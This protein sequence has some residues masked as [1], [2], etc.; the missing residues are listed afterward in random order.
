MEIINV[1]RKANG[2]QYLFQ[3]NDL[4]INNLSSQFSESGIF[5]RIE[6]ENVSSFEFRYSGGA[7]ELS[8]PIECRP[9]VGY[10]LTITRINPT[11]PASVKFIAFD[12]SISN[13]QLTIDPLPVNG[14]RLYWVMPDY[15]TLDVF[16]L[17][18]YNPLDPSTYDPNHV[19]F[20]TNKCRI[21]EIDLPNA[22]VG[23]WSCACYC[24]VDS[25][26]YI[27]SNM[28]AIIRLN[29]DLNSPDF[30]KLFNPITGVENSSYVG[31]SWNGLN[32]ANV[33]YSKIHDV[34]ITSQGYSSL[35]YDRATFT[36]NFLGTQFTLLYTGFLVPSLNGIYADN[37]FDLNDISNPKRTIWGN[38]GNAPAVYFNGSLYK[39][40]VKLTVSTTEFILAYQSNNYTSYP[41]VLGFTSSG[42]FIGAPTRSTPIDNTIRI[43]G[44]NANNVDNNIV[45]YYFDCNPLYRSANED[46]VTNVLFS[47]YSNYMLLTTA[48]STLASGSTRGTYIVDLN[49]IELTNMAPNQLPTISTRNEMLRTN[50]GALARGRSG[51][52][53]VRENY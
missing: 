22:Q 14:G 32:I 21:L 46:K 31:G 19:D 47:P 40:D 27:F 45:N 16:D 42:L 1:Y 39:L 48:S 17:S 43:F 38:A 28:Q 51:L 20:A 50:L 8:A 44:F 5:E 12:Y 36:K 30:G 3:F 18:L 4:E 15:T 53:I 10:T 24:D 52:N 23:Y 37:F 41:C 49:G 7:V 34:F 29:L 9:S 26:L 6:L 33:F 35:Y 11:L 13:K 25:S 2:F